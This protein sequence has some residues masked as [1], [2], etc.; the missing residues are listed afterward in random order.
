MAGCLQIAVPLRSSAI[1]MLRRLIVPRPIPTARAPPPTP[2]PTDSAEEDAGGGVLPH[3]HTHS[4]RIHDPCAQMPARHRVHRPR[5]LQDL[6]DRSSQVHRPIS[7][8]C[9][10]CFILGRH[11]VDRRA[12]WRL[13]A[14]RG[15]DERWSRSVTAEHRDRGDLG[16]THLG[17][18]PPERWSPSPLPMGMG[19]KGRSSVHGARN[20]DLRLG[21]TG[22]ARLKVG[23]VSDVRRLGPECSGVVRRWREL[24]LGIVARLT[25]GSVSD[26]RRLGPECSGVV[27]RWRELGLG[28]VARL[29]VG[30]VSDV[31]AAPG[32]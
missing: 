10:A 24:G 16:G 14:G 29:K 8:C 4:Q 13:A 26:V 9:A 31:R 18:T 7:G 27:R 3:L 19:R 11:Q 25:V 6:R 1:S 12:G 20:A 2:R 32:P 22:L 21:I 28:I 30:S 17:A 5:R 23:S 15:M